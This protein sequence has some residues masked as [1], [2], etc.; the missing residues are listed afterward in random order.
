M[1]PM[2]PKLLSLSNCPIKINLDVRLL[3]QHVVHGVP[4]TAVPGARKCLNLSGDEF[5]GSRKH[6][7]LQNKERLPR[8]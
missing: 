8:L 2:L 6:P 1:P 7:R 4:L 3:E 5:L